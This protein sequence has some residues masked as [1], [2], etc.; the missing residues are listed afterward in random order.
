MYLAISQDPRSLDTDCGKDGGLGC[1]KSEGE[2]DRA[3]SGG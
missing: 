3:E 2:N 1:L